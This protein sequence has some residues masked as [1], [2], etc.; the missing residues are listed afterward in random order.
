MTKAEH[1]EEIKEC[2]SLYEETMAEYTS[3]KA[4]MPKFSGKIEAVFQEI[5]GYPLKDLKKRAGVSFKMTTEFQKASTIFDQKKIDHSS[6][7]RDSLLMHRLIKSRARKDLNNAILR[8][9]RAF[10]QEPVN[11]TKRMRICA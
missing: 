6:Q 4:N 7:V 3:A 11:D 8:F 10:E 2:R 1:L 5:H 9:E